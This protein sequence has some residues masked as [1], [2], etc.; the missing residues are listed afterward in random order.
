M[1]YYCPVIESI[2]APTAHSIWPL[3]LSA[4]CVCVQLSWH[5]IIQWENSASQKLYL[6]LTNPAFLS[7]RITY[8]GKEIWIILLLWLSVFS[9]SLSNISFS[10]FLSLLSPSFL[11]TS[12]SLY[13]REA[14]IRDRKFVWLVVLY[15]HIKTRFPLLP[16]SPPSHILN[17][18]KATPLIPH[19]RK[20][21][22]FFHP[23]II[24]SL[25]DLNWNYSVLLKGWFVFQNGIWMGWLMR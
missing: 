15:L 9:P 10:P 13:L 11:S 17:E 12:L 1:K 21:D 14:Q 4:L 19:F 24:P 6:F 20:V 5:V 8:L 23:K 2:S 25:A 22:N 3:S 7:P 18:G 16:P